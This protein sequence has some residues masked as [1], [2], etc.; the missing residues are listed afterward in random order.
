MHIL[1]FVLALGFGLSSHAMTREEALQILSSKEA[2]KELFDLKTLRTSTVD[3][4][5]FDNKKIKVI[6]VEGQPPFEIV[7]QE[8]RLSVGEVSTSLL[9]QS[10]VI[11]FGSGEICSQACIVLP[12]Q[13]EKFEGIVP[14]FLM[15]KGSYFGSP[16]VQYSPVILEVEVL[17]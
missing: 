13:L 1:L 15:T 6:P 5:L 4:S 8:M 14:A 3:Q 16:V 7:T 2:V 12:K 10:N 11:N 9:V 17:R